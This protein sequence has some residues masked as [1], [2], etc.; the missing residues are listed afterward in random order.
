MYIAWTSFRNAYSR[1]IF[2]KGAQNVF[3]VV[4]RTKLLD[5]EQ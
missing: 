2:N 5:A 4:E 3:I 1:N